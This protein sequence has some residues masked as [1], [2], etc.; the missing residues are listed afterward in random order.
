L[1]L[2]I[3]SFFIFSTVAITFAKS[4]VDVEL[5]WLSEKSMGLFQIFIY[6]S[7]VNEK[8]K[9]SPYSLFSSFLTFFTSECECT[10]LAFVAEHSFSR[11]LSEFPLVT[12]FF[13]LNLLFRSLRHVVS[14]TTWD[15]SVFCKLWSL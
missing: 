12:I 14:S 5:N 15:P 3:I 9:K 2:V 4:W 10:K 11:N 13:C 6:S 1:V 7:F 8:D